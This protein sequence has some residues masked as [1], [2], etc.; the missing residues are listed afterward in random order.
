M[1]KIVTDEARALAH[2]LGNGERVE[3]WRMVCNCD[4]DQVEIYSTKVRSVTIEH[5]LFDA[6][7]EGEASV[8]LVVGGVP[9][10]KYEVSLLVCHTNTVD[11]PMPDEPVFVIC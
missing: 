9:V 4:K 3:G 5:G 6:L 1:E 2:R 11:V 8:Y 7:D 10:I